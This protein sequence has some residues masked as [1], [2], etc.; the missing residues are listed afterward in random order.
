M[1]AAVELANHQ[2]VVEVQLLHLVVIE[3]KAEQVSHLEAAEVQLLLLVV[4]AIAE[5]LVLHAVEVVQAALQEV[6]IE[7]LVLLVHVAIIEQVSHLEAIEVLVQEVLEAV[8]EVAEVE[9]QAEEVDVTR[10]EDKFIK[11]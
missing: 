11:T 6:T 2:E 3:V 1:V 9:V 10:L 7:R 4:E 5:H 8:Q